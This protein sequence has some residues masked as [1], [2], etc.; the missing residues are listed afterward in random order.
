MANPVRFFFVSLAICFLLVVA[1]GLLYNSAP[2]LARR[3]GSYDPEV[4]RETVIS[5]V[6]GIVISLVALAWIAHECA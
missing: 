5:A 6:V 2:A 4:R 3:E 1:V